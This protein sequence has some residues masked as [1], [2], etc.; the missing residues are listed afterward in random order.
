MRLYDGEEVEGFK[1]AD[2]KELQ[3][4]FLEEGMSGV[5]PTICD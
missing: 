1:E 4:E 2:L 5:D 3:T